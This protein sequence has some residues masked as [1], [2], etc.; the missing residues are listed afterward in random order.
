[1]ATPTSLPDVLF[2]LKYGSLKS[3][4]MSGKQFRELDAESV[5]VLPEVRHAL[6]EVRERIARY[7]QAL[8]KRFGDG[9]RLR[10]SGLVAVG[11]ERRWRG[12]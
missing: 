5:W 4:R 10:S 6:A 1:M 11:F 2:A 12:Q 7:R 3:V 8:Q 9:P